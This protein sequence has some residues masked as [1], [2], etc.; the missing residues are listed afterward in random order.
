MSLVSIINKVSIKVATVVAGRE[1]GQTMARVNNSIG[2]ATLLAADIG[3][4]ALTTAVEA[5]PASASYLGGMGKQALLSTEAAKGLALK[6]GAAT[7]AEGRR[8]VFFEIG[9]EHMKQVIQVWK[10]LEKDDEPK[11]INLI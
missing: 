10:D 11:Q 5:V 6:L 4:M 7:T 1:A 3:A 2:E 9:E 8:A